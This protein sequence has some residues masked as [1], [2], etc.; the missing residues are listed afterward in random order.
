MYLYISILGSFSLQNE[1]LANRNANHKQ[2]ITLHKYEVYFETPQ[3]LQSH[4]GAKIE[5]AIFELLL[6][7]YKKHYILKTTTW[8]TQ[9]L[10]ASP[11][12]ILGSNLYSVP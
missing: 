5:K 1:L 6:Q 7:R 11:I 12:F 2:K 10:P 8:L 4:L 9:P 3:C